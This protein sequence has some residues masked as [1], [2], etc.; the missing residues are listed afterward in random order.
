MKETSYSAEKN[1]VI[2]AAED[3]CAAARTAP[4]A[5]GTDY[6]WTAVLTDDDISALA[7]KMRELSQ[8]SGM[9]FLLRDAGNVDSSDAVVLIGTKYDQ[10]GLTEFCSLCGFAG[11]EKSREAGAV[12]VFD[13]MDLGI[14]IGSA[15]SVAMDRRIDNRIMFSA[16]K[17]AAAMGIFPPEVKCIMAVPLAAK[18]KNVFFDRK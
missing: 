8:E 3:M 16:G 12:C 10:R 14:A 9:K 4:K 5:K 11:C 18:G 15:V 13:P 7:D 2:R 17:A 6:I 1:A